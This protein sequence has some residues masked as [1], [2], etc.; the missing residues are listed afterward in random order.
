MLTYS[1]LKTD[2]YRMV[3]VKSSTARDD[4]VAAVKGAIRRAGETFVNYGDWAFLGQLT[5]VTYIPLET[6]YDT[7]SVTIAADSKS[8]T[9]V[10]TT[11]T[12][13]MEGA[14]LVPD[15]LE[16]YE[17][18]SYS[19]ATSL[20]LSIPYQ[21]TA[22]TENSYTIYRK[23]YDLPLNFVR[24]LAR[25]A[26]LQQV[27]SNAE[28]SISYHPDAA[29]YSRIRE[30]RPR[31]FSVQGNMRRNDYFNT[32]TVTVSTTSG[33][34]TWT[35][36]TGTLPTDI[37]D[38][39]VRIA[40]ET[41]AYRISARTGATTFTTYQTYY[42]PSDA[43]SVVSAASYAI[44]PS[45]TKVLAISEIPESDEYILCL[46]Y[47]KALDEMIASTDISPIVMAGYE[48]AFLTMCRQKL[49]EDGRVSMRADLVTNLIAAGQAA[50]ANAWS[51]EQQ[52]ATH[53]WQGAVRREEAIQIGPSWLSR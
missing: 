38:R 10:G 52:A 6:P 14:F 39:E 45:A 1:D 9:G 43:T 40:G 7:G 11:F 34:S 30:G 32:G 44:T 36:S 18:Q 35:I 24:P 12:K 42:N 16:S 15:N 25:D 27:G 26:K 2:L 4:I 48:D 21:G 37:V 8:V 50:L 53:Q 46:P 47:I 23:F 3:G 33:T 41:R 31:F 20:T 29:F 28:Y 51:Q 19:G 22:L 13:N 49:A 5:D 17:I